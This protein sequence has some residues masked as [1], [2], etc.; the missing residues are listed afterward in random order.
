MLPLRYARRWQAAGI[1]ALALALVAALAPAILFPFDVQRAGIG[2][3]KWLHALSFMFLTVWFSGQYAPRSYW[4][5][6]LGMLLF[7]LLIEVCQRMVAYRSAEATDLVADAIGIAL[8]LAIAFA[9]AGGWS[10]RVEGWLQA[11]S[12]AG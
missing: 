10:L 11:R 3:D 4:R 7:G 12:E 6:A 9:G 8:G 5:I 2:I 1:G